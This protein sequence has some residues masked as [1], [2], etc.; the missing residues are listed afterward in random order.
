MNT[1]DIANIYINNFENT[2]FSHIE[3][4]KEESNHKMPAKFEITSISSTS[5]AKLLTIVYN[6][7][8]DSK[9]LIEK[10]YKMSYFFNDIKDNNEINQVFNELNFQHIIDVISAFKEIG[11]KR[12]FIESI[13]I[14]SNL[15]FTDFCYT[16]LNNQYFINDCIPVCKATYSQAVVEK[17]QGVKSF[18]KSSSIFIWLN[19]YIVDK[20][21]IPRV[22]IRLPFTSKKK[23]DFEFNINSSND[24][25]ASLNYFKNQ[26]DT[27]FEGLT[28]SYLKRYLNINKKTL[29]LMTAE[30]KL[31]YFPLIE[32]IKI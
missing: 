22:K 24:F 16:G 6:P 20:E 11:L 4:I 19:F 27:L 23:Y 32:I 31:A 15:K 21:V 18:T 30:E 29:S 3:N 2:S 5:N 25:I 26:F 12:G 8:K 28:D 9:Q 14:P 7:D 13:D 1:N 10:N 17:L